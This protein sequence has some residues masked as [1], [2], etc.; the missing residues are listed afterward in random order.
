M[1]PKP[2]SSL[3]HLTVPVGMS[4]P[5]NVDR[6]AE[7]RRVQMQQ[8]RKRVHFV[9]AERMPDDTQGSWPGGSNRV[10]L[11]RS[12]LED[13]LS[14]RDVARVIYGSIIGLALLLALED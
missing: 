5:P 4:V 8:L 11:M 9:F 1:K 14:S 7:T 12:W 13:H 10:A 2:L 6:A 3:N